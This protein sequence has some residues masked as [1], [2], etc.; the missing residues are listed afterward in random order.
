VNIIGSVQRNSIFIGSKNV[1]IQIIK[2]DE[3]RALIAALDHRYDVPGRTLTNKHPDVL[4]AELK[5]NI[6]QHLLAAQ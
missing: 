6:Q 1:P 5:G 2:N 3:L 4:M